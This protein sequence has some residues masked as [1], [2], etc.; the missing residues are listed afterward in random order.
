M[1]EFERGDRRSSS[2]VSRQIGRIYD[3]W[4]YGKTYYYGPNAA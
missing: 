3:L 2:I 1:R 4:Q